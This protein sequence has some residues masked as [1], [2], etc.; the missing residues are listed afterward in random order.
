M[1]PFRT[2]VAAAVALV[3]A[4]GLVGCAAAT[5]TAASHTASIPAGQLGGPFTK[6]SLRN[7]EQALAAAGSAEITSAAK[8]DSAIVGNTI[9]GAS[10]QSS[11]PMT[12]RIVTAPGAWA[13]LIHAANR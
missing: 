4:I 1:K 11:V 7:A 9:L 6:A 13:S 8:S 12:L 3:V 2:L 5:T 10:V